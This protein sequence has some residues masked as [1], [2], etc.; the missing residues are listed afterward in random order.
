MWLNSFKGKF[1]LPL[2]LTTLTLLI[3]WCAESASAGQVHVRGYTRKNGTYVAPHVRSAPDGIKSN[4]YSS[5]G[6]FNP[7]TGDFTRTP[8]DDVWVDGYFRADGTYVTGYYRSA[9][10]AGATSLPVAPS[11]LGFPRMAETSRPRAIPQ[12]LVGTL[13]VISTPRNYS[14]EARSRSAY[15]KERGYNFDPNFMS[16]Y[17]MDQKVK[18]IERS[19]YWKGQ[20]YNFD[21]NFL[22][23][24]LMDQKVKDIE[25][26]RYWKGQGYNFDPNFMSAYLM[27]QKVKDI[28]RARYW[29]ERGY[30][31]DPNFMSAYWPAPQKLIQWKV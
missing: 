14:D 19:Q 10:N 22:S 4:N 24:Y 5:P 15:W 9:P 20:G 2:L 16:A 28:E 17:L 23:A 6:N 1:G 25:R 31:F 29:K 3:C 13:P 12:P 8:G 30:D 11:S 7:N 27:D 21:P 26:S 18:D